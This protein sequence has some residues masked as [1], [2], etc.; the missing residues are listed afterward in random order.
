LLSLRLLLR[1]L[2][3]LLLRFLLLMWLSLFAFGAPK[4]S[5]ASQVAQAEELPRV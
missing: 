1:L 3:L 4:A 2:L 5:R